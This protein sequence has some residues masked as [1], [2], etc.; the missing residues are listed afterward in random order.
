[1]G[2]VFGRSP[3][4]QIGGPPNDLLPTLYRLLN[5]RTLP[6]RIMDPQPNGILRPHM[7]EDHRHPTDVGGFFYRD[8]VVDPVRS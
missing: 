8:G 7:R 5:I 4:P 1:M 6:H 2:A 3:S